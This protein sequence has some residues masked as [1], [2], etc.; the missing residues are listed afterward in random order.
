ME[1]IACLKKLPRLEGK[2][3]IVVRN[4]ANG[5]DES[6]LIDDLDFVSRGSNE[7]ETVGGQGFGAKQRLIVR[8]LNCPLEVA[9]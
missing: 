8:I 6:R 7:S 4:G 5:K 9:L 1:I 2:S 3:W